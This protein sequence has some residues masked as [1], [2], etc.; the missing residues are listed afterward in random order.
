MSQSSGSYSHNPL[1]AMNKVLSKI[2]AMIRFD[3]ASDFANLLSWI[4]IVNGLDGILARI[5][6]GCFPRFYLARFLI[7]SFP[8]LYHRYNNLFSFWNF[9]FDISILL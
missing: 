3:S 6:I 5:L 7:G 8:G 1:I 4:W 9:L 2:T